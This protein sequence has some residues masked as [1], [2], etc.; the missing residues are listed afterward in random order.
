VEV[1]LLYVLLY[2]GKWALCTSTPEA[3]A[4]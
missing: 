2:V 4:H 1:L 3:A